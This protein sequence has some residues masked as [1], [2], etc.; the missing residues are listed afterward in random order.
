[1]LASVNALVRVSVYIVIAVCIIVCMYVCACVRMHACTSLCAY[2]VYMCVC[3]GVW[4]HTGVHNCLDVFVN[5][6]PCGRVSMHGR[7]K[8]ILHMLSSVNF[9]AG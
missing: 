7:I 5:T 2:H 1:M 9:T 8:F 4:M 3:L 6:Y